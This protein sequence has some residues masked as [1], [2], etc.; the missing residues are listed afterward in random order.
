MNT[1][2]RTLKKTPVWLIVVVITIISFVFIVYS[3]FHLN[4]FLEPQAKKLYYVD[5]ISQAHQ[6]I[7][8]RFNKKYEGKIEV[9]PVNLPF[10]QFTT[11]DRKEIL[12]RSLRSRSDA[13][14]VFAVDLIWIPRFAKW[15]Y[16]LNQFVDR[17][18]LPF[19]NRKA[20]AACY[21]ET[22][23]VAFPLFLDIGV[24]YYRRDVIARMPDG[25]NIEKRLRESITWDEFIKLGQRW[26]TSQRPVYVFVGGDYEGMICSFHD[27]LTQEE[28]DSIFNTNEINLTT[29]AA[30]RSLQQLVDFIY[31]FRFSPP[32][33]THFDE[34]ASY[35]YANE[36]NAL[37]YR[38]WVGFHKQYK[39]FLRDTTQIQ[40]YDVAPL[41]HFPGSTTSTVFG[42]W[43]L[44]ISKYSHRYEEAMTFV[45]F[46]FEKENQKTLYDHGGYLPVNMEV[47]EDSAYV[48]QH[49][50]LKQLQQYLE[51][52]RHR[53]MLENY[54]RISEIMS[55]TF[56]KALKRELPV[57]SA[58]Q[59]AMQQI[60]EEKALLRNA[61]E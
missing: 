19:I 26:R 54:T 13:I 16:P 8:D 36:T 35:V 17:D 4:V 2:F 27:M 33:V 49:P 44:M 24:L 25:V 22:L 30:H 31:R 7:I 50:E 5:N 32:D 14:D 51:W 29:T 40:Y 37:F 6:I 20:L 46:M 47:Y 38:G 61:K 28:S 11:N 23:L 15:G 45:R 57:D 58:L 10:H 48:R 18:M 55:R 39:S 53:P 56:H 41:P 52:G 12:T 42:G 3:P 9:V 34:F 1:F 43:S 21:Q 59:L 60:N